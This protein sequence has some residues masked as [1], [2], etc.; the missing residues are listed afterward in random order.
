MTAIKEFYVD[1]MKPDGLVE[2]TTFYTKPSKPEYFNKTFVQEVF[3]NRI[4]KLFSIETKIYT[5][6]EL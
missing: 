5:V 6:K 3:K 2:R 4:N 1:Y